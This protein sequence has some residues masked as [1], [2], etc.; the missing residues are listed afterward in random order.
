MRLTL[1]LFLTVTSMAVCSQEPRVMTLQECVDLATENNLNVQRSRLDLETAETNLKETE[2]QKY[3]DANAGGSFGYSWG[4]SID[5]TSNQFI[6]QRI[7]STNL[8]A[9]SGLNLYSGFQLKNSI[10]QNK[11]NLEA[12]GFDVEKATND[13]QLDIVTFYLNVIF[14]KELLENA[15]FQ[16][17]SSQNQL[18]RT[19][20]LVEAGSLPRSNELEL[21]SQV[22]TGDVNL[23][24]AEN[25]LT[26][27][28][29]TLKQAM[30]LPVSDNI[31]VIVPD[32]QV[33]ELDLS[34]TPETVFGRAEQT[35]PEIKAADQRVQS[36]EFGYEVSKG[37]LYPSLSLRAGL[38]TNYSDAVKSFDPSG[39]GS[40]Y[41][42]PEQF[43]DNISR[44]LSLNLTIPIFN[45]LSQRSTI[46]RSKIS[47]Q[48]AS[49][50]ALEQRNFLRQ[51]IESAYTD[52]GASSKT[53][54]ASTRQ[55]ETLEETFRSIENQ[56]NLGAS[57][58]TD[59]QVASNN[60]FQAKSDQTRAKFDFIFKKKLLDFYQGK[61]IF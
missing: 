1:L 6:T 41:T 40:D 18:E 56:Y 57:N 36:A 10:N 30:L 17:Q 24:T 29:L 9:S 45:G 26:L 4:R 31:D 5:P 61:P 35:L 50:G 2:L 48:Q 49:I 32:A 15:R 53:F 8:N 27:A 25:N 58:F 7:N 39:D 16:L 42:L 3:P 37:G 60:L 46:Q 23:I 11:R 34:I 44:F 47:M 21:I 55:V 20:I 22:A 33:E 19:K 12:A 59:Y 13:V 54:A 38:S 43:G 14:N 28:Y 52:A 51:I